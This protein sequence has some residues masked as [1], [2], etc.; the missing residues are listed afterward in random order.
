MSI[1]NKHL[2]AIHVE[3]HKNTT[4]SATV[5]MPV[6]DKVYLSMVQHIGAPCQPTVAVGD[7]VK[8]GQVIGDTDAFVSAPIHSSVSGKV[9]AI[10]KSL[11]MTGIWDTIVTIAADKT[12]EVAEGIKPPV[13]EDKASFLKAVR[14]SGLV[15]L[16]GA[17]FPTHVKFNPKNLEEVD[18]FIINGA[19]CEPYITADYRTMMEDSEL[20]IN[21]LKNTLK[22][23]G[24]KRGV[25]G[26]ESNKAPAIAKLREMV[27][28]DPE[29]EVLELVPVYPQGAERVLIYEATGRS[30]PPGKLP[31]DIGVIVSN[32]SSI[33]ALQTFIETGMPLI[34]KKITVDGN[35]IRTPKNVEVLIGT[36]I[37]KLINFCDGYKRVPKKILMGGPMM[38]RAIYDDGMAVIKNNNAILAFDEEFATVPKETACINCGRCTKA[39][40]MMLMPTLIA[41]AYECKD[42]PALEKLHATLC[43]E[44]GCCTYVCPAK[45][46]LGFINKMAKQFIMEGGKK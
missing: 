14:D 39:C 44:C 42:L 3:H 10:D 5:K 24:I 41:K 33:V 34:S 8:V 23:L 40:P 43:M 9:T 17:A 15:G 18:T 7:L 32:V 11:T 25:I 26:I 37:Y 30:I 35:A 1:F 16:G 20:L 27:K 31:A 13:V 21:G 12:Q 19:E 4:D 45:K 36:P 29:I 6:P 28:D 2:P 46:Q 22:Y 38:G